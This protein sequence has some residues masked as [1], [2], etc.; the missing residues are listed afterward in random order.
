MQS[1]KPYGGRLQNFGYFLLFLGLRYRASELFLR[2]LARSVG[3]EAGSVQDH[4]AWRRVY[5]C[6][7]QPPQASIPQHHIGSLPLLGKSRY[8]ADLA[9]IFWPL[10]VRVKANFLLG[11]ITRIPTVPSLVKSRPIAGDNAN[12][13]LL[14]LDAQRH[15]QFVQDALAFDEKH[16]GQYQGSSSFSRDS[17][18]D[19][20]GTQ[21]R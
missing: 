7:P 2:L 10:P 17:R 21:S 13:V 18:L 11:D 1:I 5:Y 16:P 9:R 14:P 6:K 20:L 12:N 4:F 19:P 8:K 15:F 3:K